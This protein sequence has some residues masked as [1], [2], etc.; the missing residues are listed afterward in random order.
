M[1]LEERMQQELLA[2]EERGNKRQLRT[3]LPDGAYLHHE[4]SRYLNLSSNDYLGLSQSAYAQID[5][6][7]YWGI[8][9][10]ERFLHGNPSSRLMTGN[11]PEYDLV[12]SELAA[13]FPD[14]HALV[15]S[16]G[17]LANLGIISGLAQSGDLI[18]ADKLVHASLIDGLRL[19]SADYK[20]FR[21]NDVAQL[22]R[23]LQS[24]SPEA[25]QVWV[26]VEAV[27]SMDGDL[28]PLREIVALKEKYAFALIVDEAHSVGLYGEYGQGLCAEYGILAEVDVIMLTFGKALAGA[29]AAVLCSPLMRDYLINKMRPLIFSTALPPHTL[30]W[31]AMVLRECRTE[32]LHRA[33]PETYPSMSSLRACLSKLRGILAEALGLDIPSSILPLHAGSNEQ[34]LRMAAAAQEAQLWVTAIRP[35]TVP[36]NQA[37]LRLSLHAAMTTEHLYHIIELCKKHG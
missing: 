7:R 12:E 2:L 21:H 18:L 3:M 8:S 22:E 4:E 27:Y 37:R 33:D 20:R 13:L 32:S 31:N 34:A 26:V 5:L 1:K 9:S 14:K 17:Y 30:L 36:E 6:C 16:S 23:L 28:A 11:S 25:G 10:Q 15:L 29:G 35:P 24:H 19:S